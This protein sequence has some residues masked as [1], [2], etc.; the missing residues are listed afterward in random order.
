MPSKS[1]HGKMDQQETDAAAWQAARGAVT[2]AARVC[3]ISFSS[4][5]AKVWQSFGA[6]KILYSGCCL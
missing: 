1:A 2:G 6:M 5:V 4:I 3:S